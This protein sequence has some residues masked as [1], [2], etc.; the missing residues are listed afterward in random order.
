M[1]TACAWRGVADATTIDALRESRSV[2]REDLCIQTR[3]R[4]LSGP[5]GMRACPAGLPVKAHAPAL[6]DRF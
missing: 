2:G 6:M 4:S 3:S 5:G 1:H